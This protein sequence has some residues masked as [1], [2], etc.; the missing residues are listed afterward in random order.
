MLSG[1]VTKLKNPLVLCEKISSNEVDMNMDANINTNNAGNNKNKV[2][3]KTTSINIA[4]V[5]YER[6]L[7]SIRPIPMNND[8]SPIKMKRDST[9]LN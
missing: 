6:I 9:I 4:N 1:K 8:T 7:F 3:R 5:F 2:D